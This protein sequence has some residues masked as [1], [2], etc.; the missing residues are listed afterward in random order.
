MIKIYLQIIKAPQ[1]ANIKGKIKER[2]KFTRKIAIKIK[3]ITK[4][5]L[6][7]T[8]KV[9]TKD[10]TIKIMDIREEIT[11]TTIIVKEIIKIEGMNTITK[12]VIKG[13]TELKEKETIPEATKMSIKRTIHTTKEIKTLIT[14]MRITI[15]MIDTNTAPKRAI[16]TANM[17]ITTTTTITAMI[18]I[19]IISKAIIMGVRTKDKRDTN[20]IV[21]LIKNKQRDLKLKSKMRK[22]RMKWR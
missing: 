16:N 18:T 19:K 6:K 10:G 2:R 3:E 4:G 11:I 20:Q 7:I 22:I 12:I 9:I 17:I 8:H 14:N 5:E 21:D 15:K 1:S 13:I